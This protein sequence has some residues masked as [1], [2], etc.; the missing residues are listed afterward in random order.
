M[1]ILLGSYINIKF[2]VS[3]F[4]YGTIAGIVSLNLVLVVAAAGKSLLK[5]ISNASL[6]LDIV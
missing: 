2:G 1:H 4:R 6:N 3:Y 5:Q